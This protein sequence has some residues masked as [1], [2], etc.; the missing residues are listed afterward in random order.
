MGQRMKLLSS[1][2][3]I[4]LTPI[5][6]AAQT[7]EQLDVIDNAGGSI[8][9]VAGGLEL[10]FHLGKRTI[11]DV[12]LEIVSQV[13]N[14]SVLNLKRTRIS[15]AGLVHIGNMLT[16][17]RLHL[18]ETDIT[19]Q[20][21]ARLANLQQLEYL[22]LYGTVITDEGI[23]SLGRLESL[24]SLYV[25]Q[26][27]ITA[28]GIERL[29]EML[30]QTKVITGI[31]LESI[32]LPDPDAPTMPPKSILK[33]IPTTNVSNA[34]KSGNGENIEIVFENRSKHK[35]KVVWVGYDGKLKLYGELGAGGTRIQNSYEN[36]TWL[37]LDMKDNPLGYFVCGDER[38]L[39]VIPE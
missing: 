27:K 23:A 31:D 37:I 9:K 10:S 25:W 1:L 5:A 17:R 13:K 30:P 2:L 12:D 14:V 36:N 18:E 4:V 39:A 35:V 33:F 29:Q 38:A 15:D 22:N 11:R 24:S 8:R 20:G 7:T 6:L 28:D 34:P 16:L 19:D 26:T 3:L 21:L 32:V